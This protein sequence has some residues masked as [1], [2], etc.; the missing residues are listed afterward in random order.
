[1]AKPKDNGLAVML[2]V[3]KPKGGAPPGG[4]GRPPEG[5]EEEEALES[6]EEEAAESTYPEFDIP[7]GLDLSDM[8]EGDEKEV[9][10][11]IRKTA[12]GACLVKVD[13]VDLESGEAPPTTGEMPAAGT[14][15]MPAGPPPGG[16]PG[17]GIAS[18]AAASG[19]M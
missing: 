3:G 8:Q 16:P 17:G 1:M 2:A 14:P 4:G 12:D 13:G 15:P 6:P 10:A 9:L 7:K 5:S 18:R 11:T 19:L